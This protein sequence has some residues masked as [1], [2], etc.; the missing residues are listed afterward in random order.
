MYRKIRVHWIVPTMNKQ[1]L[2]AARSMFFGLMTKHHLVQME[3]VAIRA[4]F[5]VKDNFSAGRRKSVAPA[6]T[7][8]HFMIGAQKCTVLIPTSLV[9]NLCHVLCGGAPS[10]AGFVAV[11]CHRR[12]MEFLNWKGVRVVKDGDC[13]ALCC[14]KRRPKRADMLEKMSQVA[15]G[16]GKS[17]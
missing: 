1:K 8:P 9:N 11:P 7:T 14:A 2:T 15:S 13:R 4:R 16:C 6:R 3:P 12:K 10:T 17:R 5:C